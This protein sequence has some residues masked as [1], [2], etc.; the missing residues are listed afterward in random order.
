[1]TN[2][3]LHDQPDWQALAE[4]MGVSLAAEKRLVLE[5]ISGTIDYLASGVC[6][7]KITGT[8]F[9]IVF[10]PKQPA[11]LVSAL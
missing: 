7:A 1:M 4:N 5:P 9:D 8:F 11:H 6:H 2:E 3:K 10:N